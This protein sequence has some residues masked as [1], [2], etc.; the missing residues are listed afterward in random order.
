[1]LSDLIVLWRGW[2][3]WPGNRGIQ[4]I[5][6]LLALAAFSEHRIAFTLQW[7]NYLKIAM[8]SGFY[9]LGSSSFASQLSVITF[10]LSW[11]TN[12]WATSLVAYKMW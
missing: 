2:V 9:W 11:L 3:L 7:I 4:V 5:S 8:L 12:V 6:V 1:M 10:A